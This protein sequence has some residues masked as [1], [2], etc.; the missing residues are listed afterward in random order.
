MWKGCRYTVTYDETFSI[1]TSARLRKILVRFTLRIQLTFAEICC[2]ILRRGNGRVHIPQVRYYRQEQGNIRS[3]KVRGI[4]DRKV[5][6]GGV[7]LD[8]DNLTN[9]QRGQRTISIGF[10]RLIIFSIPAHSALPLLVSGS[11]DAKAIPKGHW[12]CFRS[13]LNW[14]SIFMRPK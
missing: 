5:K 2:T 8:L 3:D 13:Y 12:N 14:L 4:R 10:T 6:H 7:A 9:R 11:C 1:M